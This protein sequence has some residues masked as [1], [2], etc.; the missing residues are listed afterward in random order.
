[1]EAQNNKIGI[2]ERKEGIPLV[3]YAFALRPSVISIIIEIMMNTTFEAV[4]R[5]RRSWSSVWSTPT[6]KRFFTFTFVWGQVLKRGG[7]NEQS[8]Q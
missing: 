7:K 8:R 5:A 1:M 6:L 4:T 2:A 3:Q